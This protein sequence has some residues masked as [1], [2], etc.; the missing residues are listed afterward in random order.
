MEVETGWRRSAFR[1]RPETILSRNHFMKVLVMDDHEGFRQEVMN[2]LAKHGHVPEGAATAEEAKALVESGDFDFVLVDYSMPVHDG[3]WFMQHVKRP[4]STKALL[5]TAHVD[6]QM[7]NRMFAVGICGYLIKPFDDED[8]QRHLEFYSRD[9]RT[10]AGTMHA[11]T[12]GPS[13]GGTQP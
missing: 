12:A 8:L 6:R 13:Q 11:T 10:H 9:T 1:R 5:V 4:R 2:M 3:L 7:I